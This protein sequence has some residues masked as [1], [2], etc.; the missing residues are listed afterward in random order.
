MINT[1]RNDFM[2]NPYPFAAD[3]VLP[4]PYGIIRS[5]GVVISE[6]RTSSNGSGISRIPVVTSIEISKDSVHVVICDA[7]NN[8]EELFVIN[9]LAGATAGVELLEDPGEN[10]EE[11][12]G[13]AWLEVGN[14]PED[15]I[16]SYSGIFKL[17]PSCVLVSKF[18]AMYRYKQVSIDARLYTLDDK[19]AI[20]FT[21]L[22]KVQP[23]D[24]YIGGCLVSADVPADVVTYKQ[25]LIYGHTMVTSINGVPINDSHT[26]T[27]DIDPY[28]QP[29]DDDDNDGN[30]QH[31]SVGG[32]VDEY[33]QPTMITY[34]DE[35][36]GAIEEETGTDS[37]IRT[38]YLRLR[39]L[40][41]IKTCIPEDEDEAEK[42]EPEDD[43]V[44]KEWQ[45]TQT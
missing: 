9:A 29:E 34:V 38:I 19:L 24:D 32:A 13:Y 18:S 44:G 30:E 33:I 17:A 27:F 25:Q 31:Q 7:N 12:R 45:S 11:R 6:R 15:A 26:L 14:I 23:D 39:G 20:D 28:V 42:A 1:Y 5:I 4:F 22:F 36:V 8:N 10:T 37:K 43:M 16:G 3:T 2:T 35:I 40:T 41:T 21:G